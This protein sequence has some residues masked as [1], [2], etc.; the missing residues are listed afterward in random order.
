MKLKLTYE[1]NGLKIEGV[2][3]TQNDICEFA[4]QCKIACGEFITK[5][6]LK[7]NNTS[8]KM[9]RVATDKQKKLLDKL[10]IE[11]N[12]NITARE[13]SDLIDKHYGNK[14]VNELDDQ[15]E[16]NKSVKPASEK[17]I[18]LLIN[19][20]AK[21]PENLTSADASALIDKIKSIK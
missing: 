7:S 1:F 4:K 13:A 21:I 15:P 19:L 5:D 20:G 12:D 2:T 9:I 14:P 18:Q 16:I 11:Y 17:Q 3:E 8:E 6:L 10:H